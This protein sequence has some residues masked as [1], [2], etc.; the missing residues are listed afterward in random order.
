[1]TAKMAALRPAQRCRRI[2]RCGLWFLLCLCPK[3]AQ[4][5]APAANPKPIIKCLTSHKPLPVLLQ[6]IAAGLKG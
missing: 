3:H 2:V 5:C 4:G 6:D 1:M